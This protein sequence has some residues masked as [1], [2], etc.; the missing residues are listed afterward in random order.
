MKTATITETKNQFSVLIDRVRQGETILIL[1]RK[2][3]VARLEPARA[4]PDDADAETVSQL[5]RCGLLRRGSGV[6][7]QGFL[8]RRLPLL[9]RGASAVEA[10]LKEREEGR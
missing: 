1:D 7:P 3:P 8:E 9:A 6:L 5:E 4:V 2:V 10:L